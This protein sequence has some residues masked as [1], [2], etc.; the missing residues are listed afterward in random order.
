MSFASAGLVDSVHVCR[1]INTHVG[2]YRSS[3]T[4]TVAL[5]VCCGGLK[6]LAITACVTTSQYSPELGTGLRTVIK[7]FGRK[8]ACVF[9]FVIVPGRWNSAKEVEPKLS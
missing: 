7:V 6:S 2:F 3:H 4:H 5:S 1:K 9:A 8:V